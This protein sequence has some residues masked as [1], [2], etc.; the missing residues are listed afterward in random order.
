[1]KAKKHYIEETHLNTE[2]EKRI[3]KAIEEFSGEEDTVSLGE[4]ELWVERD[5]MRKREKRKRVMSVATC[6]I[7]ICGVALSMRYYTHAED[8]VVMA[9][10]DDNKVATEVDGNTV[11]GNNGGHAEENVG[12]SEE[13]HTTWEAAL[14]AKEKYPDMLLPGYIPE[15]YEFKELKVVET[16]EVISYE[17]LYKSE[18]LQEIHLSQRENDEESVVANYDS[19]LIDDYG[20]EVHIIIDEDTAQAIVA[21]DNKVFSINGDLDQVQILKLVNSLDE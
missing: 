12:G 15:G 3:G 11:I 18:A 17:F 19:I 16:N 20:R 21:I 5:N 8:P 6:F 2:F 13:V 10:K 1:M 9:G 4:I 14:K 7:I